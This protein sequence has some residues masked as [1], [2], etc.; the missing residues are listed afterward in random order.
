MESLR[1]F[2]NGQAMS[3]GSLN[4]ALAGARFLGPAE[5]APRYRFYSVRDEFP[6]LSPVPDGG[7]AVP[8]ELYEVTYEILRERLLPGEP[9]ELELGVIEL[10]DGS[11]SL[12]MRMRAEAI[13]AP[14]VTDISEAGGWRAHLGRSSR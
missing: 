5:T 8:G 11:G 3:G 14:G 4:D 13:S 7:H 9:P 2:V 6:G 10:S 1:M 12:C